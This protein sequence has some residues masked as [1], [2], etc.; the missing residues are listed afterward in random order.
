M[1][2]NIAIVG[3][4]ESTR[5]LAPFGDMS[6]EIWGLAWRRYPRVDLLFEIHDPVLWSG[7][8][9]AT[10]RDE[11][12]ASAVPVYMRTPHDDIPAAIRYPLEHI[13]AELSPRGAADVWTSSIAYMLALAIAELGRDGGGSIGLYGVD[14]ALEGEY[15]YQRTACEYLIGLARGRGITVLIP[16][17]STLCR[18][19]FVYGLAPG[20]G[21]LQRATGIT[22]GVLRKRLEHYAA[23]RR[24]T[25]EQMNAAIAR[26]NTLDG[27]EGEAKAML[28]YVEHFNRGGVMPAL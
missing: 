14:M 11:L 10:Y 12:A 22:P 20:A 3:S 4:A 25:Q 24:K 7:Y 6:W 1:V 27:A 18:A 23:E 26:L 19:N 9:P 8:A 28:D 5:D 16:E 2:R 15:A 17:Q 13:A 21:G